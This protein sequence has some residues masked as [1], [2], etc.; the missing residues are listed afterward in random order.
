MWII[1]EQRNLKPSLETLKIIYPPPSRS[2]PLD[3][4]RRDS[5]F[6]QKHFSLSHGERAKCEAGRSTLGPMTG[7][8]FIILTLTQEE[9]A[10]QRSTMDISAW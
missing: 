2:G 3:W 5:Q 6:T 1:H 7:E 10:R 9:A 4:G 8:D